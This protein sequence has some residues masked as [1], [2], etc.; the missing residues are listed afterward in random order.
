MSTS[1]SNG[2][3]HPLSV[4][5]RQLRKYLPALAFVAMTLA[6][7]VS[8]QAARSL[9]WDA[10][11]VEAHLDAR[12][13]LQVRE[14]QHMVFDGDWNGGERRFALGRNQ[15]L[16]MTG[17]MRIDAQGQP[18]PMTMGDLGSVDRYRLSGEQLLRWRSRLPSDPPFR[19]T[20]LTYQIDYVLSGI[21]QR[22]DGSYVLNHDFGF[23]DRP[24][25]INRFRLRLTL[26]PAWSADEAIPAEIE[27]RDLVPGVGVLLRRVLQYQGVNPAEIIAFDVPPETEDEDL[28]IDPA[29]AAREP[30][31]SPQLQNFLLS[32]FTGGA[33]L[34]ILLFLW[35]ERRA[36][37]WRAPLAVSSVDRAWLDK[38]VFAHPPEVVGVLWD[39]ELGSAEVAALLARLAQEG[40]ISSRVES[41]GRW[42][43]R[44]HRLHL[45]LMVDRSAFNG[46]EAEL[47]EALFVDGPHTDTDKVRAH[48]GSTGFN[49]AHSLSVGVW[50]DVQR[51]VGLDN[52]K[53]SGM[54]IIFLPA[55]AAAVMIPVLILRGALADSPGLS[56]MEDV[57]IA[58]TTA[59]FMM[60]LTVF[61][62]Q[63][64]A[65]HR[66]APGPAW[67]QKFWMGLVAVIS[68]IPVLTLLLDEPYVHSIL[69]STELTLLWLSLFGAMLY[70]ARTRL[71]AQTMEQRWRMASARAWFKTELAKPKPVLED[72]WYPYLIALELGNAMDSWF[73]AFGGE[74]GTSQAS[75]SGFGGES[76]A[77]LGSSR[78]SGGGGSFGGAGA[79]GAWA[80]SV[81]GMAASAPSRSSG[82]SSSSSSSSSS[83]SSSGGGGGGGW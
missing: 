58:A 27:R 43:F 67:N 57:S 74:K 60:F 34:V 71:S 36:G 47:V 20:A 75:P 1:N 26:D 76:R 29:A 21:L 38:N 35:R 5:A 55:I 62:S 25:V 14:T 6:I 50:V 63:A 32:L 66:S 41:S 7:P 70:S 22:Q 13:K 59:F 19:D 3:R 16:D 17:M 2:K 83:R 81:G 18:H 46:V 24:G 15:R 52:P 45:E 10:I 68:A 73:Q 79:T 42:P 65:F 23:A 51:I 64:A 40:K 80:E 72:A 9:H 48:Y 82:S 12:G 44:S 31:I 49:P 78:W 69:V 77:S 11:E 33:L 28:V 56:M 4:A 8:A 54:R 30:G 61:A 39:G 37:W 53:S